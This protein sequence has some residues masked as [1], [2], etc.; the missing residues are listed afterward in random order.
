[1]PM[2]L[3]VAPLHSLDQDDQNELEHYSFGHVAP[4][5]LASLSYDADGI[6]KGTIPM[7]KIGTSPMLED[8]MAPALYGIVM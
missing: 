8:R 3:T 7:C 6:I 5:A 1:M 2:A 4:L